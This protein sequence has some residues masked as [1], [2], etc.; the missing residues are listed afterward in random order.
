M[1]CNNRSPFSC[2]C[3][4][5]I[6]RLVLGL[7]IT[8]SAAASD[9][10][11]LFSLSLT[12]LLQVRLTSIASLFEEDELYVGSSVSKVTEGQ[13]REQGAEK[14]FDA[15]EHLPGV[16]NSEY[17]HGMSIPT[18]RGLS[19]SNQYN[20]FLVLLDGMPVNNYS[21][22]AAAYGMPNF[23]LGNLESIEVIR[24]PGSAL[25]GA[26]A[27]NG[28][29]ALNSWS[30]DSDQAQLFGEVGSFGFYQTTGRLHQGFTD[31]VALTS[32]LSVSGTDDES[33]EA[34]FTPTAGAL[35]VDDEVSGEYSNITSSHKLALGD[36]AV[37]LY[38][39]RHEVKDAVGSGESAGLP[40]GNHTDGTAVMQA[41][42]LSHSAALGGHW[43][44][45][46]SL[47][48]MQDKLNGSFG[49]ASIGAPPAAVGGVPT[50]DW[51][52]KD[53]HIGFNTVFKKP[54]GDSNTQMLFGYNFEHLEVESFGVGLTGSPPLAENRSRDLNGL[55]AQFEQRLLDNKL[56]L[57][58]G[59]RF[60][61]YSDFG[62]TTSPRAAIIYHPQPNSAIKLLYG[63]AYRSP[64][65]NEQVDNGIVMG[66]DD[67]DPEQVDTYELIW[68]HQGKNWRYSLTAY[69]SQLSDSI[70]I[71]FSLDPASP[72]GFTLQYSNNTQAT[73][74]GLE[75]EAA[76]SLGKWSLSG[77]I[78]SNE[79]TGKNIDDT[80]PAYP[81]LIVNVAVAY[82]VSEQLKISLFQQ[83][84]DERRT[85][86][87]PTI[88]RSYTNQP[89][90]SWSRTDLSV[91]WRPAS[92]KRYEVFVNV[93]DLFDN[94]DT[95]SALTLVE[96]GHGTPGLRV[97]AGLNVN[98]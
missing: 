8:G 28:V 42:K 98:F 27:F 50:L 63:N 67:L 82:R 59:G 64:S 88:T 18:F 29:V 75:L 3:R 33:I 81:D 60:D 87:T 35:Q 46:S 95:Q 76:I 65:L 54:L 49:I 20:S 91:N 2:H 79:T 45:D 55:M 86:S 41:L 51:D 77:N 1:D 71:E 47:F 72:A 89:L 13:W 14:T 92:S 10:G 58:I 19:D 61:H 17:F 22:A 36:F 68:I 90:S 85:D 15:I 97:T 24:G 32:A 9:S 5:R 80:F 7:T 83:Y 57:I 37:G 74:R 23:A 44:A 38:Y 39:S 40:N 26:N 53:T 4:S 93:L 78:A 66:G 11:D 6:L 16:Y 30:S 94:A 73:A 31:S 25:Y 84:F 21:S 70:S 12:E 48:Y 96:D 69:E 34:D 56:Q 43:Q 62:D 52:S